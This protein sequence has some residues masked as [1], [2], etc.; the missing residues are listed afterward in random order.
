MKKLIAGIDFDV[1]TVKQNQTA[2][3]RQEGAR[4]TPYPPKEKLGVPLAQS[5]PMSSSDLSVYFE[6][7]HQRHKLARELWH[8]EIVL[9]LT[10][11]AFHSEVEILL[12]DG[13][14]GCI[15]PRKLVGLL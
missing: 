6:W 4:K 14:I 3:L 12:P 1:S 13:T 15:N 2:R 8:D 5:W 9:V 11:P 10:E 7:Q